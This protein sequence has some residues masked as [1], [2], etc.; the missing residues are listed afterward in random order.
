M[1]VNAQQLPTQ[2]RRREIAKKL[3]AVQPKPFK[4]EPLVE[5]PNILHGRRA[6][7]VID[8][9]DFNK[10]KGLVKD[11][12]GPDDRAGAASW[13]ELLDVLPR[14]RADILLVMS[15]RKAVDSLDALAKGL[16][17]FRES[18]PSADVILINL[19]NPLTESGMMLNDLM[20]R[21]LVDKVENGFEFFPRILEKAAK[22]QDASFRMVI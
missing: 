11:M 14:L 19:H 7:V 9:P 6:V 2:E 12:L 8:D 20:V 15:P 4:R 3:Q 17:I 16:E 1:S 22:E 21:G 18:N 10:M 5:M 13:S